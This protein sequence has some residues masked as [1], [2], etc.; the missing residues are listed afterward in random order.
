MTLNPNNNYDE[1][2]GPYPDTYTTPET[3]GND[4]NSPPQPNDMPTAE[5]EAVIPSRFRYFV[6]QQVDVLDTVNRW[7]EAEIMKVDTERGRL[8]VTYLFW[9][10]KYDEWVTPDRVAPLFTHTYNPPNPLKT[11]QRVECLDSRHEW[12]Q[13]FVIDENETEVKVHYQSWDPKFDEWIPRNSGR[14]RRYGPHRKKQKLQASKV[15]M[16]WSIPGSKQTSGIRNRQITAV[17]EMYSTYTAALARHN[18]TVYAVA[19][20]GNCLFRSVAHQIYR[21]D[22]LHD[23]VREKCM[24]YMEANI[25]F[26]SQ[27][28]VGGMETFSLYLE[29]KRQ[30]GCWGDDPEIQAMCEI[31][32]R[33][34]QIWAHDPQTGARC[35][36]TFHEAVARPVSATSRSRPSASA[37]IRL[38]YYGG[39]HYDSLVPLQGDRFSF[40]RPGTPGHVEERA[41]IRSLERN[42]LAEG[43][44]LEEAQRAS[45][46]EAT[47]RAALEMAIEASRNDLANW[48]DKDLETCLR[49]S[50]QECGSGTYENKDTEESAVAESQQ[51]LI[52]SAVEQSEKE[53]IEQALENSLKNSSTYDD[54]EAALLESARLASLADNQTPSG[55]S[56]DADVQL[57][58]EL[59]QLSEEELLARAMK[60]SLG[61]SGTP[62]QMYSPTSMEGVMRA[63]SSA[64][65]SSSRGGGG[66][67]EDAD[68]A[69]AIRI[70]MMT[71]DAQSNQHTSGDDS[72]LE[73]AIQASF[74]HK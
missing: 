20:D 31:Y 37:P 25:S 3:D 50:A 55:V 45:D 63:Q 56:E 36:R 59:S 19:G 60:E 14:F 70:S 41:I 34:A 44:G 7:S 57:A 8:F 35:L 68:I 5:V 69:E 42:R 22:S 64:Y 16:K 71:A 1:G 2:N 61:G 29:A 24:D 53:F 21:D 49:L 46:T 30:L 38:S 18:L 67:E 48:G 43:G 52:N 39:G 33:A 66:G 72:D 23:L 40:E 47:E 32:G 17:S 73:L 6:G 10:S 15:S 62:Q 54:T 65:I 58:M 13:A 9:S 26:F 11:G 74:Q 51:L 12:L 4:E 28:V 27:F